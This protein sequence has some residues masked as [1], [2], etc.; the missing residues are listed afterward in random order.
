[1]D[2]IE[3][4][5]VVVDV[6]RWSCRVDTRVLKH[7]LCPIDWNQIKLLNSQLTLRFY[8][9]FATLRNG[10]RGLYALNFLHEEGFHV[11]HD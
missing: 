11:M 9:P 4:E 7:V 2:A 8:S 10:E 5:G 6:E 1:M 3:A